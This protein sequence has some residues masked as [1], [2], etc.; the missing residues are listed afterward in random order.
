MNVACYGAFL[1]GT[2][3]LGH[4]ILHLSLKLLDD[5]A[6]LTGFAVISI[7]IGVILARTLEYF[8]LVI[9]NGLF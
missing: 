9:L 4:G 6:Y 1:A 3:K 2:A 8:V 7:V 5:P